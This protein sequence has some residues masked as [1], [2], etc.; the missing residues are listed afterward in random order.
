MRRR[1]TLRRT[2]LVASI[3]LA[4][5]GSWAAPG[6]AADQQQVAEVERQAYFTRPATSAAPPVLLDGFPPSTACLVAGLAGFPE[7]CGE[8]ISDVTD[9]LGLGDG[10]PVPVTPDSQVVQPVA[11]GT[12]P[13]GMAA[14]QER[15]AS[16]LRFN[17]PI[18]PAGQEFAKIELLMRPDGVGYAAES[19]AFRQMVLAAI[20]QVS[21][22]DPQQFADVLADVAAG[23]TAAVAESITGIEA[24]PATEGWDGGDA[25]D[26]GTDGERIPDVDCLIGTTGEFDASSDTWVFDITFAVQ[27]WTTGGLAGESIPNEGLVLRPLGAENLAYGDPDL[28]TNWLVSLAD[29]Q[30]AD[31]DLRPRLR[32]SVAPAA[33][34]IEPIDSGPTDAAP[35]VDDVPS[36]PISSPVASPVQATPASGGGTQ[37]VVPASLRARYAQPAAVSTAATNPWWLLL[38]VPMLGM[39]G[40]SMGEAVLA[41]PAT[42]RTATGGALERLVRSST[43]DQGART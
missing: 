24:C 16:L 1:S 11:P 26:A 41:R 40:W 28:S 14:G 38:L 23:E 12:L 42:A 3:A 30:A 9:Q 15:Y 27:A 18:L 7:A 32:Y 29:E 43:P 34:P 33:P 21:D 13:I 10:L 5:V 39:V 19:P 4:A 22:Q 31:E 17:L 8:D 25:Q 2:M 35:I 36:E 20:S 6:R 37:R